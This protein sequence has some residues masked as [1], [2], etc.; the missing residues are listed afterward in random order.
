M[1]SDIERIATAAP[2]NANAAVV[3]GK[4][5]HWEPRKKL[6]QPWDAWQDMPLPVLAMPPGKENTI[7]PGF[8]VGRLT[9]IG[10]GAPGPRGKGGAR[11]VVRCTC[12]MYGH[13]K[14]K[15]LRNEAFSPRA[16]CPKCN[17]LEAVKA[18]VH[19]P[20]P[21]RSAGAPEPQ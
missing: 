11:Y 8:K 18:G 21:L 17:Y 7:P 15:A 4:G 5:V 12:G 14:A 16:M 19:A 6:I 2:A 13:Q 9:V 20:V 1:A 3:T 10:Y